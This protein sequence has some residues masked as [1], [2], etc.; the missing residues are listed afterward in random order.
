MAG[1]AHPHEMPQ[2]GDHRDL[3]GER[4]RFAHHAAAEV[5]DLGAAAATQG[6][7]LTSAASETWLTH[8]NAWQ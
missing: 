8:G 2:R 3:H 1:R 6:T 7:L 4:L 5:V